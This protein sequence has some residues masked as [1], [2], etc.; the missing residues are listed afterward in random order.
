[1]NNSKTTAKTTNVLTIENV[2]Y[3]KVGKQFHQ[4]KTDNKTPYKKAIKDSTLI[5]ALTAMLPKKVQ[6]LAKCYQTNNAAKNDA[7]NF[8][9][10]FNR[11]NKESSESFSTLRTQIKA[12][13]KAKQTVITDI[14]EHKKGFNILKKFAFH[15][16]TKTNKDGLTMYNRFVENKQ[17]LT[18]PMCVIHLITK[19]ARLDNETYNTIYNEAVNLAPKK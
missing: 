15:F 6:T 4:L 17:P 16:W 12:D 9:K 11:F 1:M 10:V 3:I 7:L 14:I 18:S 13:K 2:N 5:A 8:S 19:I